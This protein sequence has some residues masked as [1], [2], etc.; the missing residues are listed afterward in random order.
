M[1]SSLGY[2]TTSNN[3]TYK[4]RED[5][6]KNI[7]LKNSQ[8]LR[9]K[10]ATTF[11]KKEEQVIETKKPENLKL[12]IKFNNSSHRNHINPGINSEKIYN[13]SLKTENTISS[14]ES[15]GKIITVS[16]H[17]LFHKS[18]NI[19]SKDNKLYSEKK[20]FEENNKHST[21]NSMNIIPS[22]R[23][24]A[25][26]FS[27]K[28]TTST[29]ECEDTINGN[30]TLYKRKTKPNYFSLY[31]SRKKYKNDN[32]NNLETIKVNKKNDLLISNSSTN[33]QQNNNKKNVVKSN[34][35]TFLNNNRNKNTPIIDNKINKTSYDNKSISNNFNSIR[36]KSNDYFRLSKEDKKLQT[37]SNVE[38][39]KKNIINNKINI[40]NSM[41]NKNIY[42]SKRYNNLSNQNDNINKDSENNKISNNE[43][44]QKTNKNKI[45]IRY[46]FRYLKNKEDIDNKAKNII[47]KN[48]KNNNSTTNITNNI[49]NGIT[50]NKEG[51]KVFSNRSRNNS[52]IRQ[53][54]KE[55][56]QTTETNTKMKE[57]NNHNY[58]MNSAKNKAKINTT[59]NSNNNNNDNN[60]NNIND[61]IS[62][63]TIFLKDKYNK[64]NRNT[65]DVVLPNK[66]YKISRN[67]Q[68]KVEEKLDQFIIHFFEDLINISNCGFE[69]RNDFSYLINDINKKYIACFNTKKFEITD[70][71]FIYCF[72]YFCVILIVL[73]FFSK[74]DNLYKKN[75]VKTKENVISYIYSALCYIGYN[76]INHLKINNFIKN[77]GSR[78]KISMVECTLTIISTNLDDF[79]EYS[80]V[81]KIT[82]QLVKNI[83]KNDII[84]ILLVINN[85][86][87]YCLNTGANSIFPLQN[88]KLSYNFNY[89]NSELFKK[90][91]KNILPTAP[92]IKQKM[93]KKFCLILDLDETITYSVKLKIGYY[94]LIRPGVIEFLQEIS[95]YFEI[96]FFTSS[97]KAYADFIL[98]KLDPRG[99]L[100]SHRLYR[101]HVSFENG[102]SV[103]KLNMIGRDLK[104]IVFVDNLK[105]NA[106]YNPENLYLIPSWFGDIYDKEIEKL[107]DK[108]LCLVNS[109][110]YNDDITQGLNEK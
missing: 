83:I 23:K 69:S 34:Y 39:K 65:A 44:G 42:V 59:S 82:N 16:K 103:K 72:K 91:E 48:N 110:K 32:N 1:K 18:Q 47:K 52:S 61:K 92:F 15:K 62:S 27:D 41:D 17:L 38:N 49:I 66:K 98:D 37:E 101:S 54:L 6:F 77:Y 33:L 28:L 40:Y 63:S 79:K 100:I 64:Y 43:K 73:I 21:I 67:L 8:R 108:L 74:D 31:F 36:N 57:K 85:C 105:Y 87:L 84:N 51:N 71:N 75:L 35:I 109:G 99:F 4:Q 97:Y 68:E 80:V 88:L 19:I 30:I 60:N 45:G 12:S 2:M 9:Q 25:N 93:K 106:K 46:S 104:K 56:K 78:K 76:T 95:K 90:E 20:N 102:R 29:A 70:E 13:H 53:T 58:Y 107:K 24:Q 22:I 89:L 94:F 3:E 11:S 10:S 7:I 86:V 14:N 96:I 55:N 81:K 26:N 50:K 5:S